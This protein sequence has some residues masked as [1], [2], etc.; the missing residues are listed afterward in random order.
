MTATITDHGIKGDQWEVV[1]VM[2]F[3]GYQVLWIQTDHV[4]CE[5]V[6]TP[7]GR[8][9]TIGPPMKRTDLSQDG[10]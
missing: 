8:K 1:L 9:I 2:N 7:K 5:A 3:E 10:G 6:I 4:R